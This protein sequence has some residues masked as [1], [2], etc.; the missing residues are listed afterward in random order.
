M[1]VKVRPGDVHGAA[2]GAWDYA[3]LL[4]AGNNGAAPRLLNQ[5][6]IRVI[7][8]C[9]APL[10]MFLDYRYSARSQKSPDSSYTPRD[11]VI[12]PAVPKPGCIRPVF[13]GIPYPTFVLEF[14]HSKESYRRLKNDTRNK[15][16]ARGTGIRVAV[17]VKIYTRHIRAFWALRSPLGY[18]MKIQQE[19]TKF[20]ANAFTQYQFTIPAAEIFYSC[21]NLPLLSSQNLVL[22][23]ETLRIHVADSRCQTNEIVNIFFTS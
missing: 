3:I 21:P 13:P 1:R 10:P 22:E 20:P 23:L 18:G 15:A 2:S 16:F 5:F 14:A 7:T 6:V 11:A 9:I 19:T 4:W 17:G 8:F 12:P